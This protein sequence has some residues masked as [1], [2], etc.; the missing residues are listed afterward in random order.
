S[1]SHQA[2]AADALSAVRPQR[3][4]A[5]PDTQPRCRRLRGV[6]TSSLSGVTESNSPHWRAETSGTNDFLESRFSYTVR[7]RIGRCWAADLPQARCFFA[8]MLMNSARS[9]GAPDTA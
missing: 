8:Q 1:A 5:D 3:L 4:R 9:L 2:R 7:P 6:Q